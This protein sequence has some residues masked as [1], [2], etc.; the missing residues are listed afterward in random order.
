MAGKHISASWRQVYDEVT[1][2]VAARPFVRPLA[3]PTVLHCRA[4]YCECID[5][6]G[7][8]ERGRGEV[9]TMNKM[10]MLEGGM[11]EKRVNFWGVHL[12]VGG[13]K[14]VSDCEGKAV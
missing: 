1:R 10:S 3:T 11:E 7:I 8:E 13:S 14:D 5:Q 6:G 2:R 4:G 12:G 9:G